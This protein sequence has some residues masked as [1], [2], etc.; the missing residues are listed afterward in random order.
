MDELAKLV[1][2]RTGISEEQAKVAVKVVVDF[3]KS[4]LPTAIGSQIDA[5]LSGPNVGDIGA[6]LGGLFGGQK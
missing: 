1:A 2:Q 5:I 4:K 3:I 6:Q